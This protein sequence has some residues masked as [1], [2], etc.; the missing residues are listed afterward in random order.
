MQDSPV[1]AATANICPSR[2]KIKALGLISGM[3]YTNRFD[4]IGIFLPKSLYGKKYKH[5]AFSIFINPEHPAITSSL[6]PC[7]LI[8]SHN[9]NL[10]Q[11]T[12][13]FTEALKRNGTECELLDFPPDKR[14]THAFSVFNPTMDESQKVIISMVHF[15]Q[16]H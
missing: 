11:Y 9:D 6:P 10:R 14:L 5:S 2:L 16:K 1:L 3:F 7:F 13:D 12:I 8:T 15:F 4:E